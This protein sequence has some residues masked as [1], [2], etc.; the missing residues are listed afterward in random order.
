MNIGSLCLVDQ[1]SGECEICGEHSLECTCGSLSRRQENDPQLRYKHLNCD[2][3]PLDAGINPPPYQLKMP[4]DI[5]CNI[6]ARA[7]TKCSKMHNMVI[8]DT[9]NEKHTPIDVCENCLFQKF[10]NPLES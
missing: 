5:P 6:P 8:T 7:C 4:Y 1:M 2:T 3:V 10:F 9:I